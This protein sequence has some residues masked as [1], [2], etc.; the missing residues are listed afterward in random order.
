MHLSPDS[1]ISQNPRTAYREMDGEGVL[2]VI[3][4]QALHALNEVG[5]RVWELCA[6]GAS[7]DGI[8]E[9]LMSEFEVGIEQARED[10]RAFVV[11]LAE[12]GALR[13]SGLTDE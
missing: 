3:D 10:V 12:L 9:T 11:E 7:I 13:V 8:A 2:M 1:R 5:A 6:D 4:R